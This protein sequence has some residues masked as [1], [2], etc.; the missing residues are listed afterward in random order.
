MYNWNMAVTYHDGLQTSLTGVYEESEYMPKDWQETINVLQ[1]QNHLV[2]MMVNHLNKSDTISNLKISWP[3]QSVRRYHGRIEKVYAAAD[4]TEE[5]TFATL[6]SDTD[7]WLE[8][9][10]T[11]VGYYTDRMSLAL[12]DSEDASTLVSVPIEGILTSGTGIPEGKARV[13]VTLPSGTSQSFLENVSEFTLGGSDVEEGSSR[14]YGAAENPVIL[15]NIVGISRQDEQI[16]GTAEAL[17]PRYTEQDIR[18]KKQLVL[19]RLADIM[20]T[21]WLYSIKK[22]IQSYGPDNKPL[23]APAGLIQNLYNIN[24]IN[25]AGATVIDVSELLGTGGTWLEN[26]LD[27]L[28]IIS[29]EIFDTIPDGSLCI[30]GPH[31][32]SKLNMLARATQNAMELTYDTTKIGFRIVTVRLPHGDF[33]LAVHPYMK[34]MPSFS[35]SLLFID[36]TKWKQ[37]F[38]RPL[39]VTEQDMLEVNGDD[40]YAISGVTEYTFKMQGICQAVVLEKFGL[41]QG[42]KIKDSVP[43]FVNNE[44]ALRKAA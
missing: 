8:V 3:E 19:R 5:P 32:L 20:E 7:H 29:L 13:K 21:R 17:N 1:P 37:C 41:D 36:M 2:S 4:A 27:A 35:H 9:S 18:A 42:A 11:S 34:Y 10:K 38:L 24:D 28:D 25:P 22:D 6:T 26:G 43:D 31:A 23:R 14:G 12:F 15:E 39:R 16:T 40:I 33:T 44:G 30:A